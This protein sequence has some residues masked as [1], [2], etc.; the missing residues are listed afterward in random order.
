[1][2]LPDWV[3]LTPNKASLDNPGFYD[4]NTVAGTGAPSALARGSV[5]D[6]R[7][8]GTL[9][10]WE[11]TATGAAF[12]Q[13]VDAVVMALGDIVQW[14]LTFNEPIATM[15]SSSY[16]AGAWPPGFIGS[17]SRALTVYGDIISAHVTAY[18]A[19]HKISP[20]SMVGCS[21]W[22]GGRPSS[23]ANHC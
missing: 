1:M 13:Y 4:E 12:V 17:G 9:R 10:G 3:L 18:D 2:A 22:W 6:A 7:Y 21:Q 14:W 20:G 16:L 8:R 11:T 5:E 15:I 19:I 23:S